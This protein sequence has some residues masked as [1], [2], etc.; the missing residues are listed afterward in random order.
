MLIRKKPELV[1]AVINKFLN[2]EK[3]LSLFY[4]KQEVLPFVVQ[5]TTD[6]I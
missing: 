6:S 2:E 3:V 1:K 4:G 5:N